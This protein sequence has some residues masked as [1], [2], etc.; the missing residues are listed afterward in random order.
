MGIATTTPIP[1]IMSSVPFGKVPYPIK[2][3]LTTKKI[4]KQ[5]A[6]NKYS[7]GLNLNLSD[8]EFII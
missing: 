3:I 7:L 2:Y 1:V 4:I 5:T 6:K 8:L